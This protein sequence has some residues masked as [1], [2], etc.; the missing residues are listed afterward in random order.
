MSS[1]AFLE[2]LSSN[3]LIN[4]PFKEN[5]DL[6]PEIP[7]DFIVDAVISTSIS[8]P[9]FISQIE[10]FPTSTTDAEYRI[11]ING[12]FVFAIPVSTEE[13][14]FPTKFEFDSPTL[15]VKMLIGNNVFDNIVP[16]VFNYTANDTSFE[17]CVVVPFPNKVLSING[18]TGDVIFKEGYNCR[19]TVSDNTILYEAIPGAGLGRTPCDFETDNFIRS[20]NGQLLGPNMII[21][22]SEC[23]RIDAF[24][25]LNTIVFANRCSPCCGPDECDNILDAL[26][27]EVVALETLVSGVP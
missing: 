7:Q 6:P 26:E 11:S 16:N 2:F 25:E 18:L 17:E 24:P 9:I 27:D 3:K 4:Y 14:S 1:F 23:V 5:L 22:D 13:N 10:I 21:R 15:K 20:I 12:I 8:S 19:L